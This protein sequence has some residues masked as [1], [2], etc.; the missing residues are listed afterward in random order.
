M[1]RLGQLLALAGLVIA[2]TLFWREDL[3]GIVH[4]LTVAGAGLVLASVVHVFPMMLNAFAWQ[5]LFPPR[6]RTVYGRLLWATWARESVTALLP[7]A[8]IGGEIVAFRIVRRAAMAR[9]VVAATIVVDMAMSI[10]TQATFTLVGLALLM[11]HDVTRSMVLQ[12][13]VAG[14][15]LIA[16]GVA[17]VAVQ[18]AGAAA[19]GAR[20]LNR[21]LAGRFKEMIA[22]SERLDAAIAEIYHRRGDLARCAGWQCLGWIAGT[23]EIWLALYFHGHPRSVLDAMMIDA[24]IQAISSIVFVIPGA[25]GVQEGGFLLL[26]AVIGLDGSSAL[27]L[28]AAR[29]VRDL[30]VYFPGL[31]AWHRA[32]M[33]IGGQDGNRP[34]SA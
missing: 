16:L 1:K 5:H 33:R 3:P 8:R 28:A 15:V 9:P 21:L 19:A 17:F 6:L 29:R 11:S 18:R 34:S 30:V 4:L 2:A 26:G 27:A 13:A 24:L 25:L 31:L 23:T 22:G 7:V 14:G 10:L 20:L 32:E 12:I